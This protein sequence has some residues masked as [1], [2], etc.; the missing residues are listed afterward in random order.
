M[1]KRTNKIQQTG[2]NSQIPLKINPTIHK[3]SH[4]SKQKRIR[5]ERQKRNL[6]LEQL[7]EKCDISSNF[8]GQ[9]ERGK[10]VPSL[11]SLIRIA[12]VLEVSIDGLL[13]ENL[14]KISSQDYFSRQVEDITRDFDTTQKQTVID[15]LKLL[16]ELVNNG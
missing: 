7:A 10:N 5:E 16:K 15:I 14:E 13:F 9:L 12:N 11:K 3:R 2:I 4:I 8:L 1:L 6:T